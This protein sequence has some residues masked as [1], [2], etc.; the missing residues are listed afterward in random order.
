M[1]S[2]LDRTGHVRPDYTHVPK[3]VRLVPFRKSHTGSF[4][5]GHQSQIRRLF[6]CKEISVKK[7][8]PRLFL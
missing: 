6:C 7:A 4:T 3:L 8:F 1:N 2:V 5:V